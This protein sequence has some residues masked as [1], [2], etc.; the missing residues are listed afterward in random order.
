MIKRGRGMLILAVVQVVVLLALLPGCF[1]GEE[2]RG[3]FSGEELAAGQQPEE[4]VLQCWSA[5]EDLQP[6]VYQIRA[7]YRLEPEQYIYLV[8]KGEE[9]VYRAL[10]TEGV[11]LD[12]GRDSVSFE[13][14]VTDRISGASV[15][16]TFYAADPGQLEELGI[17]RVNWGGRMVL[18]ALLVLFLLVDGML[19]LHR[20]IGEGR[21]S[22]G[23]QAVFWV[24]CGSFVLTC[25]P[26]L[27]DYLPYGE[28]TM[29][30]LSRIQW[31]KEGLV[32]RG[33]PAYRE[34]LETSGNRFLVLP[35]LIRLIG[36]SPMT[37][38]KLFVAGVMAATAAVAYFSFRRCTRSNYAALA[39]SVLYLLSW[40]RLEAVYAKGAMEEY[41]AMTFFPLFYCGIS[42]L[43]RE[44]VQSREYSLHKWRVAAGL[45]LLLLCSPFWAAL[46]VIFAVSGGLLWD[47]I[48]RVRRL[49][50]RALLRGRTLVQLLEAVGLSLLWTC[51][52]W[53]PML[54]LGGNPFGGSRR[55]GGV[56][57]V[58]AAM[59]VPILAARLL[60]GFC[61]KKD[62]ALLQVCV[63]AVVAL[64]VGLAL[65]QL[66][67]LA[68]RQPGNDEYVVEA[69][70]PEAG[71]GGAAEGREW[72]IPWGG[73]LLQGAA[74]LSSLLLFRRIFGKDR[75]AVCWGVLLYAACPYG[76]YL[77][78]EC[79]DLRQS[80]FWA[81]LPLYLRA[82]LEIWEG[83]GKKAWLGVAA[84]SLLLAVMGYVHGVWFLVLAG[85]TLSA[86]LWG[87]KLRLLVAVGLGSVLYAPGLWNLLQYLFTDR[88]AEGGPPLISI[89]DAGYTV[90]D[91]FTVYAHRPGRPGLGLGL[92]LGITAAIW[93]I[94][95]R[96]AWKPRKVC[97]FFTVW[98]VLLLALSSCHFPWDHVERLGMWALKLVSLLGSP[99]IFFGLAAVCL[100]I[101][102]AWALKLA[103]EY[104]LGR[105]Q[106][107]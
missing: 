50:G 106:R 84:G 103:G 27:T 42:L 105:R 57:A 37:A 60:E 91:M 66:N 64:S 92:L 33:L 16:C 36:F 46:S 29:E 62:P 61:G 23:Q 25:L 3:S 44:K 65:Y 7:K 77:Y 8:L 47:G 89:M 51:W 79:G 74:V 40:G 97:R 22:L 90:G 95:V 96:G 26:Y 5:P 30:N 34:W 45:S 41:L 39:G 6:G 53:L 56:L 1:R 10:R 13:A 31:L 58:A 24:L 14:Y 12:S 18:C 32:H 88:Y 11:M 80:L 81:L 19:L 15:E 82:A 63:F 17:Y 94:W 83:A 76:R 54:L 75:L 35:V 102:A 9:N 107:G 101:P 49:P 55:F 73:L 78:Y 86:A 20:K 104:L 87:K 100:C 85:V 21:L 59:W 48:R 72:G 69:V 4:G 70:L 71:Q 43:Y 68:L 99:G 67:G 28:E 93:L 38:Y 2:L 52:D 98:A